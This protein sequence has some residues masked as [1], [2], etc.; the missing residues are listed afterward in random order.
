MYLAFCCG[1]ESVAGGRS[2]KVYS[3]LTKIYVDDPVR[4]QSF[5]AFF[6]LPVI[7]LAGC[8]TPSPRFMSGE[9]RAVSVDGT[10]FTVYRTGDSVEVYRTTPQLLPRRSV[11]FAS[12][13]RAIRQATGCAVADGSLLGDVALM[14]ATLDCG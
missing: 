12:A 8:D 6:A 10:A 3:L 1:C 11:V 14:Q 13:E 2:R 5:I 4:P 9:R 7:A